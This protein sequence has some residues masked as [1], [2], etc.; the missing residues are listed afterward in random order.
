MKPFR[1]LT[2][3]QQLAG[4]L[5]GEIAGG[6][7]GGVLPGA[8]KLARELGVSTKTM[9]AAVESLEREGVVS[10]QGARR[11]CRIMP[12]EGRATQGLRVGILVYEPVD[13]KLPYI[14]DLRHTLEDAGH[15]VLM[16]GK[17]LVEL[18]RDPKRVAALV[19]QNPVD[20]WVVHAGSKEV[21][22]WFA[23][24]EI[25]TFAMFGRRRQVAMAGVGP[26]KV[27][28]IRKAVERLPGWGTRASF[29]M[30]VRRFSKRWRRTG[31]R[32]APTTCRTGTRR[33]TV[34]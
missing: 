15:A 12:Q 14:I 28:A 24:S 11:R 22:E 26:D 30:C 13:R 9:M 1:A 16:A 6:A 7:W 21:L 31:W 8:Q 33:R 4:H 19:E 2:A 5:R 32:P 20:A 18:K 3:A 10:G 23:A 27:P 17:T 25:P 29:C 34:S